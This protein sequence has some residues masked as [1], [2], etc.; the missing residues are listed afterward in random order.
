MVIKDL[1]RKFIF[2]VDGTLTPPRE[3]IDKE[4]AE[5]FLFF[6]KTNLVYLVTGSDKQKTIEQIGEELFNHVQL[7]FNCAGNEIWH[8][9]NLIYYSNWK[10]N[11]E[12]IKYLELLLNTSS[13]PERSGNHIEYRKGMVNFSIIGRKC[14]DRQRELYKQWDKETQERVSIAQKIKSKFPDLDVYIG[15]ETGVDI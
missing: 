6:C 4:F 9:N 1:T 10:P 12:V 2:D 7:S 3:K 13:F 14:T 8:K 15:G 5:F 11:N